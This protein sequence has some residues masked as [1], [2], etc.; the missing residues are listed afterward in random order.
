MSSLIVPLACQDWK[1]MASRGDS[2]PDD[3]D[4]SDQGHG[5]GDAAGDD[6]LPATLEH[7]SQLDQVIED[8]LQ[9]LMDD[10]DKK[11]P[12][13]PLPG[14]VEPQIPSPKLDQPTRRVLPTPCRAESVASTMMDTLMTK[15]QPTPVLPKARLHALLFLFPMDDAP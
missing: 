7:A 3:S 9:N 5:E 8:D 14:P 6:A 11:L 10:L 4:L 15:G 1:P 12:E 13:V 2:Q